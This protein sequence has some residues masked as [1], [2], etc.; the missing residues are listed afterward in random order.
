VPEVYNHNQPKHCLPGVSLSVLLYNS[1][2]GCPAQ[3]ELSVTNAA[4]RRKSSFRIASNRNQLQ[5]SKGAE[6]DFGEIFSSS[7][8]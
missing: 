4:A 8:I 5:G 2:C 3:V 6:V 1:S 7:G